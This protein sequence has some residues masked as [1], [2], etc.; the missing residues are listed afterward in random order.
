MPI[1]RRDKIFPLLAACT[2]AV[3]SGC[4]MVELTPEGAGVRL[5]SA[6]AVA[7]CE[8][9]GKVTSSVV[10][11][12]AGVSRSS[13]SVQDNLNVTARNS[14]AKMGADTIVP[15]SPVEDGKQTFSVYR[16]LRR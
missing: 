7:S 14:A 10:A 11:K 6:E 15:T 8:N 13:D 5:A 9:L 2:L 4:S 3:L 1:F 12:V 16:C